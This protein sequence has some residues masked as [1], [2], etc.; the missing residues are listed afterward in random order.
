MKRRLAR[1]INPGMGFY[2]TVLVC[3][4]LAAFLMGQ[5]ILAVAELAVTI[6]TIVLFA[7]RRSLR[8]KDLARYLRSCPTTV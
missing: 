8:R 4:C 6:L 1:L 2:Y 7:L 5:T 3:F